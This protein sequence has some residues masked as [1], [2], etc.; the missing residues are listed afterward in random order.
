M[1]SVLLAIDSIPSSYLGQPIVHLHFV[2]KFKSW[3]LGFSLRACQTDVVS[4]Q[5]AFFLADCFSPVRPRFAA[6][7]PGRP[8]V[9]GAYVVKVEKLS[10][11]RLSHSLSHSPSAVPEATPPRALSYQPLAR[12][13]LEVLVLPL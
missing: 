2:T 10:P 9:S 11:G 1:R 5:P 6:A 3:T 4:S 13:H 12:A 7:L 8:A